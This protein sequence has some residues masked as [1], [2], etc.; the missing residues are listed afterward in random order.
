[1]SLRERR[2][3]RAG[4]ELLLRA[5]LEIT[6]PTAV[7]TA[8]NKQRALCAPTHVSTEHKLIPFFSATSQGQFSEPQGSA[9]HTST[10]QDAVSSRQRFLVPLMLKASLS[11]FNKDHKH[12]ELC[13]LLHVRKQIKCPS[14][15]RREGG[16][17]NETSGQS[18]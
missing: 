1:M 5:V 7:K 9:H 11:S 6:T 15:K 13:E 18:V 17:R 16:N 8:M 2:P 12:E 4:A 3:S 10:I 14:L